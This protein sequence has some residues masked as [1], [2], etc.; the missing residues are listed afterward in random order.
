MR[1]SI[2]YSFDIEMHE[3]VVDHKPP[4]DRK[5][6]ELTEAYNEDGRKHRKYASV[7]TKEQFL[8]FKEFL[9]LRFDCETM[10]MIGAPG[11]GIS[12]MPALSFRRE[13]PNLGDFAYVCPVPNETNPIWGKPEL[14][15]K[16][17]EKAF[18][19]LRKM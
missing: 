17:V 18:E 7:L 19:V 16:Y 6:W 5:L 3:N 14:V 4:H 1:F 2:I 9:D 15:S 10:G 11:F 12:W 13:S 8:E